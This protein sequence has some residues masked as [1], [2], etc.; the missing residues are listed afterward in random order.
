MSALS[1]ALAHPVKTPASFPLGESD[2]SHL[3][4]LERDTL[5]ALPVVSFRLDSKANVDYMND[6]RTDG[7]KAAEWT[8]ARLDHASAVITYVGEFGLAMGAVRCRRPA[9]YAGRTEDMFEVSPFPGA[10][11]EVPIS[12]VLL[13]RH[14][15]TI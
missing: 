10:W 4:P 3:T 1:T 6:P 9:G 2:G 12:R 15:Q 7:E 13:V 5:D 11:T 8:P 14:P